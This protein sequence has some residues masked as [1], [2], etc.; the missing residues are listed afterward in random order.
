MKHYLISGG[1]GL[2][3]SKL[4]Q[5]L[6]AE[7]HHVTVLSRTPN[8]VKDKCGINV[9][10]IQSLTEILPDSTINI[11]INLAGEPIANAKWTNKRKKLLESSRI[12]TTREIVNWILNRKQKPEC[13]ISGSA[14]GWYGDSGDQILT[15]QS[16]YHDEYTH[17]LC[18]AWEQQALQAGNAGIRV[19]I[20]RTGLVL[21]SKGGMLQKMLLP[22]KLNLGG[23]LGDGHQYMPWIHISDMIN[24]L[25]FLASNK[26]LKGVF[27]ASAPNPVTNH[28]FTTEL[29]KQLHRYKLLP[30]PKWLL[31]ILLGEM[32]SLLLTGQRAVP[33][34]ALE[35]GFNFTYPRLAPALNNILTK[36]KKIL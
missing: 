31:K 17:K 8:T 23:T 2:I 6:I 16:K 19:C 11:V 13:F 14:V 29:A 9:K 35:N 24:L 33:Q 15:E 4:C 18:A 3:G 34:R 25:I 10:A 32:S 28:E 20:V 21:A 7:G 26:D 27:N 12:N 36:R 22:F 30:A 5:Q 1:S